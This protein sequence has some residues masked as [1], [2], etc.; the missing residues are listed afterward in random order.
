MHPGP[1]GTDETGTT[2]TRNAPK[3]PREPTSLLQASPGATHRS[4]R[5]LSFHSNRPRTNHIFPSSY[6]CSSTLSSPKRS[7]SVTRTLGNRTILDSSAA[8][9]FNV[10][11]HLSASL[12]LVVP[13]ASLP[14][15]RPSQPRR[16]RWRPLQTRLLSSSSSRSRLRLA[17]PMASPSPALSA[18]AVVPSTATGD[19]AMSL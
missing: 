12:L 18:R 19:K 6:L 10:S 15:P 3:C 11:P 17:I 13:V 4:R 7:S 14:H 1:S 2:K 9:E 16:P 8:L 5:C